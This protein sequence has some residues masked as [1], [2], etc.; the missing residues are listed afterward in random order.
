M[1]VRRE[2]EEDHGQLRCRPLSMQASP[3]TIEERSWLPPFP[4]GQ[5]DDCGSPV[6]S[7]N[8][9]VLLQHVVSH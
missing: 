3:P 7:L 2:E 4:S 5:V 6:K 8:G 9:K 1:G